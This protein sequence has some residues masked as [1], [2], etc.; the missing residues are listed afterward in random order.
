M[1]QLLID[2]AASCVLYGIQLW[3]LWLCLAILLEPLGKI[4]RTVDRNRLFI[5]SLARAFWQLPF[6][7]ALL[8][9]SIMMLIEMIAGN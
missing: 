7:L 4:S 9:F 1:R 5:L 3:F 8:I 2:F 6:G